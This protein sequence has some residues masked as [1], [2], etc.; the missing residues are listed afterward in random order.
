MKG[1]IRDIGLN[2]SA[3]AIMEMNDQPGFINIQND[4][5]N[6]NKISR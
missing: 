2:A 5:N 6:N 1:I 3:M 4:K